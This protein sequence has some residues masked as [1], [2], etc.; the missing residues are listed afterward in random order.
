MGR[1]RR[2]PSLFTIG[3]ALLGGLLV[4]T[5][6]G[7]EEMRNPRLQRSLQ[8]L[9]VAR[10]QLDAAMH[11]Y[12]P[13]LREGAE[14]AAREVDAAARAIT[15]ELSWQHTR[16]TIEPGRAVAT[17]RPARA[18]RD[19][20]RE[21]IDELTRGVSERD[22]NGRVRAAFEHEH[23]ALDRAEELT[24]REAAIPTEPPPPA[25]EMRHPRLQRAIQLLEVARAHLD[26]SRADVRRDLREDLDRAAHD[27]DAAGRESAEALAAA[28]VTRTIGPARA[29]RT[30]YPLRAAREALRQAADELAAVAGDEFHGHVRLAADRTRYA[31]EDVDGLI[32]HDEGRRR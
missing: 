1:I 2:A 11:R 24:R 19:S 15:D 9:E 6:A 7:A 21:A 10:A 18:A 12:P 8:L 29:E 16:R 23:D 32:R 28:G 22:M 14:R 25:P 31:M 20:L 30:D 3:L 27:V 4:A 5:R 13:E 26:A 17:D